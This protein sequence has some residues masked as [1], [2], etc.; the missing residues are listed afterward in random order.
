[1]EGNV[2]STPGTKAYKKIHISELPIIDLNSGPIIS[3]IMEAIVQYCQ[4]ELGPMAGIF[5][6]GSY[7]TPATASYNLQE[8]KKEEASA[9][10]K[11][12]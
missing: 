12:C 4:R 1:M 10:I 3:Q 11:S 9:R 6:E 5:I 2:V 8:I 7:R